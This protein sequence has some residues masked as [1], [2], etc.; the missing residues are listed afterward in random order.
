VR[1]Q[2]VRKI[3]QSHTAHSVTDENEQL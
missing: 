3:T 1:V 2:E